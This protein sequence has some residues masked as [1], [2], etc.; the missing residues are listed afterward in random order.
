[1]ND[2]PKMENPIASLGGKAAAAK[3]TKQERRERA[4]KAASSRWAGGLPQATH[5]SEDHPLRIGDIEIPCYVL[6]DGRRVLAQRGMVGGLNMSQGTAGG[7][8]DRLVSFIEGKAISP[9]IGKEL[10]DLIANPIRFRIP[11]GQTTAYGYEATVLADLCD[12]V[13]TARAAGVLQKQQSHIAIQCEIL[14]RGFA[15]VG[16]I[17]L[18]D[19]ATGYQDARARDAL[20]KILEAF[21]AK[22]LRPY[23]RTFEPDFY[24]AICELKGWEFKTSSRRPRALAQIT[25]DLVYER[26]APGVLDELKKKNPVVKDGRRKAKHFQWLTEN[27]G[28]P[29]LQKHLAK[30][31]GWAQMA[32]AMDQTWEVFYRFVN[33]HK[34]KY[35]GPTLFDN[36]PPDDPEESI[37]PSSST[38]PQPPSEQ[39]LPAAPE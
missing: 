15:R 21:I 29:E 35:R 31:T 28:H 39:S 16:I 8:G 5:G 17:A 10:H 14:V 25:N 32:R 3:M 2:Q 23:V 33:Q 34:P 7:T 11:S 22:E 24:K 19:E 26:L 1:M 4:Q 37:N 13:L 38:V 20:A 36:L 12:A 9:Y 30:I 6:E 18:V 27:K